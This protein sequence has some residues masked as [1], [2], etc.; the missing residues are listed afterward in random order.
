M[1]TTEYATSLLAERGF[2]IAGR[3]FAVTTRPTFRQAAYVEKW[4]KS[5][6]I[7]EMMQHFDPNA[8]TEVSSFV[9]NLIIESFENDA[10]FHVLA[11]GLVEVRDGAPLKWSREQAD[12]FA[13]W[14]AECNDPVDLEALQ[15]AIL[16]VLA[17]FFLMRIVSAA[18][19]QSSSTAPVV[20]DPPLS[21][22]AA[23]SVSNVP[24]AE[25]TDLADRIFAS[26]PVET[27]DHSTS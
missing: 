16:G 26:A 6:K 14:I 4:R 11:G 13:E 25:T 24:A 1:D 12:V 20:D 8:D 18:T 21:P 3:H 15:S 2:T 23:S 10:I 7:D 17:S 22:D 19:S 5:A 9:S 27:S